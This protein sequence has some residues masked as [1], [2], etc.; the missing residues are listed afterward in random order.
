MNILQELHILADA[1]YRLFQSRLMPGSDPDRI[2]GVR[3]PD[4][5]NLAKLLRN[6]P[7]KEEFFR[8]LPHIFYEENNLHGLL[9]NALPDFDGAVSAL[10]T[11]LPFV[12]NWATCDLLRPKAF[13]NRQ[14]EL[15]PHICR[16]LESDH[17]YT[18]RFAIE[19]LMVHC[20]DEKFDP[21]HLLWVTE[22]SF[23]DHYY[24]K[25]MVA[26][27]LATALITQYERVCDLLKSNQLDQ[28]TRRKA[29]QKACESFRISPE[30]KKQLKSLR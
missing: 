16:W 20:L 8:E 17:P 19:M 26:W 27:Y 23:H 4:L 15:L 5:R 18:L 30:Q 2:L 24:V 12:D 10:D 11:F 28:W 22:K 13:Q 21:E 25:M 3:T 7:A 1:D 14:S 29:I 6:N 9:I